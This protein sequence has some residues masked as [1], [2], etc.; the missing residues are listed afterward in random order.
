MCVYIYIY[1]HTWDCG[2]GPRPADHARPRQVPEAW[3]IR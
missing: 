2:T 3:A 1:I